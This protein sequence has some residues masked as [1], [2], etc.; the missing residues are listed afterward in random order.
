MGST[1]WL[2][3]LYCIVLLSISTN[4][5]YLWVLDGSLLY[6][7]MSPLWKA[8]EQSLNELFIIILG[9]HRHTCCYLIFQYYQTHN[10]ESIIV[11]C[12]NSILNWSVPML[13]EELWCHLQHDTNLLSTTLLHNHIFLIDSRSLEIW[14]PDMIYVLQRHPSQ[15]LS[16]TEHLFPLKTSW[17]E[18]KSYS[19]VNAGPWSHEFILTRSSTFNIPHQFFSENDILFCCSHTR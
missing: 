1:A 16:F 7:T 3:T 19:I 11:D 10:L 12:S 18:R 15:F 9:Y 13:K 4:T 5:L 8:F 14:I 17:I 6:V 2:L